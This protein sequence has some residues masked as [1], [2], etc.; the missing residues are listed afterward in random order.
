MVSRAYNLEEFIKIMES[1]GLRDVM[2]P[3][4]LFFV[5]IFALMIKIKVFGEGRARLCV[6]FALVVAALVVIPHVLN[7]YPANFDPVD[8]VN[9]ALPNISIVIVAAVAAILFVGLFGGEIVQRP[10]YITGGVVLLAS[11][12]Y[13]IFVYPSLSPLLLGIAIIFVIA[14]AFTNP[15]EDKF[16]YVQAGVTIGSFIVVLYFFGVSRGW[17]SEMPKWIE[18]PMYQGVIITVVIIGVLIGYV[19]SSEKNK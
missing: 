18:D 16:N 12:I 3:F 5:L 11:V 7:K 17:F 1:W 8:I 4:L 6:V 9:E 13:L 2:L 14:T 15:H 19:S 10:A